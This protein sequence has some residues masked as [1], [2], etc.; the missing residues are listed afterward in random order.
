MIVA[1]TY[2]LVEHSVLSATSQVRKGRAESVA[3]HDKRWLAHIQVHFIRREKVSPAT[4]SSLAQVS[5]QCLCAAV[6]RDP[7]QMCL[8]LKTHT[9]ITSTT[10][11]TTEFHSRNAR[12]L[13]LMCFKVSSELAKVHDI[14][15]LPQRN[16]P[17]NTCGQCG[18]CPI[19]TSPTQTHRHTHTLTRT[20]ALTIR[21]LNVK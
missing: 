7:K 18:G 9:A 12:R 20:N 16:A 13:K 15:S 11:T 6:V 8:K 4:T 3:M 19:K 5:V 17:V 1:W 14:M 21:Q 10:S 2:E